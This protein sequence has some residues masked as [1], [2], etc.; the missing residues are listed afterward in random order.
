[1]GA[2]KP[3]PIILKN[4]KMNKTT[5]EALENFSSEL[6]KA[7]QSLERLFNMQLHQKIKD[8]SDMLKELQDEIDE[9]IEAGKSEN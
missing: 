8:A 3:P 5:I 4:K 2:R 7:R 6:Y 1:M 9:D